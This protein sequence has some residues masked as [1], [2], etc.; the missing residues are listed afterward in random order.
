MTPVDALTVV[1]P[2]L[3]VHRG[4]A[5]PMREF[6]R[7]D[8]LEVNVALRGSL[9]YLVGGER[10]SVPE[11]STAVFWAAAPHRLLSSDGPRDSDTCWVH[12]PLAVVLRWSLPAAFSAT[13]MSQRTVVVPTAVIGPHVEGLFT[14]WQRDLAHPRGAEPDT[15]AMLLEANAMVLRILGH[16]GPA[17]T[18][19]PRPDLRPVA[20]MARYT[21]E[22]FRDRISAADIARAAN[23]NPNYATTLFRRAT[24]V[25]LGDQLL[26]HRIAEA[27][28]LLLTTSMTTAAVAHAA[29]FGS[30][31]S[32]Y[33]HFARA[34]GC[35]PGA[36]RAA[37]P[38]PAG[39]R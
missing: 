21:A 11:G 18:P 20:L 30:G 34:C 27:Q 23:L 37:R 6:H 15:E 38:V 28:R 17:P 5:P 29:G 32:L 14:T 22:N 1:E 12:L 35:S 3:W 9:E 13:V 10:V 26:R 4:S 19:R 31:S 24:G 36:Y 39:A 33:A 7:H 16:R 2:A 8:D 25:T